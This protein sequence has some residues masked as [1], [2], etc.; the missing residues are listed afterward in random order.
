MILI[1]G[2]KLKEKIIRDLKEK[3][4]SLP[5]PIKIAIYPNLELILTTGKINF[6]SFIKKLPSLC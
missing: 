5:R 4:K 6:L 3:T 1:E 2:N